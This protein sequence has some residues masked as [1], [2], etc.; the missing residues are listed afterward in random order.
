M[1]RDYHTLRPF[2]FWCQKVLPLVYD[3]SLSYYEL[4][5]KVV[6]YL[7]KT[8]EDLSYFITNWSTPIPVDDYNDFTE[9]SK[10]YLYVGDQTG[11]NKGHWYFYN[12]NTNQWEDGGLYG[13]TSFTI[14]DELSTESKNAVQNKVITEQINH[15]DDVINNVKISH[16]LMVTKAVDMYPSSVPSGY[17][18][19]GICFDT[20]RTRFVYG[21]GNTSN[22]SYIY[23]A[24]LAPVQINCNHANDMTYDPVNDKILVTDGSLING[25]RVLNPA[26]FQIEDTVRLN[27]GDTVAGQISLDSE[28]DIL[29]I[30]AGGTLYLYTYSTKTFIRS[31]PINDVRNN[32]V[33]KAD[34]INDIVRQG[35]VLYEGA[36][37]LMLDIQPRTSFVTAHWIIAYDIETGDI[38]NAYCYRPYSG[39]EET[40]AIT[41]YNGDF[42]MVGALGEILLITSTINLNATNIEPY[43][44]DLELGTGDDLDN[45]IIYGSYRCRSDTIANTLIN[46][47]SGEAFTMFVLPI[48]GGQ[49]VQQ[50]IT[51]ISNKLY[52]RT[53][54]VGTTGTRWGDL[55]TRTKVFTIASQ[56]MTANS[57]TTIIP[58]AQLPT[59]ASAKIVGITLLGIGASSTDNYNIM[60]RVASGGLQMK[61]SAAQTYSNI[62]ISFAYTG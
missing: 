12:P 36:F 41:L 48:S 4:L 60:F 39:Q 22:T 56:T 44:S 55:I 52:I 1:I 46:S 38:I 40:E 57:W 61:S 32:T 2:R 47:P 18:L 34:S 42:Y 23:T 3:D 31:I 49:Y 54:R 53:F 10:I 24:G 19:G 6:D 62:V 25:Y 27:L 58:A 29:A 20:L 50:I 28:N 51:T 14:D 59:T 9:T 16:P 7:N 33:V 8:R 35:G 17:W 37:Y 11:Y 21:F 26:T 15:L 45:C 30:G 43:A 13:A 5:A